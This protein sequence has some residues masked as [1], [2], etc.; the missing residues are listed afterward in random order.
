MYQNHPYPVWLRE[1]DG[2]M[3]PCAKGDPGAIE[4]YPVADPTSDNTT[5][6]Q[7]VLLM[8]MRQHGV[9]ESVIEQLLYGDHW[10]K[11]GAVRAIAKAALNFKPLPAVPMSRCTSCG[12]RYPSAAPG[13]L[14]KC[15]MCS[16]GMCVP[17]ETGTAENRKA[18]ILALRQAR[19]VLRDFD[20]KQPGCGFWKLAASCEE[21]A[22]YLYGRED[23]SAFDLDRQKLADALYASLAGSYDCSRVWEAWSVGTMTAND[24]TP[25]ED[26]ALEIAD[27]IIDALRAA[28][29]STGS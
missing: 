17:E 22:D 3:H 20:K 8:A 26:R 18:L 21:A 23:N 14:H 4:F 11:S 28:Q 6:M 19:Y 9:S 15:G 16:G 12:E 27:D 1:I 10:G 5:Q 2:S 24:F 7:A 25:M 29:E 13:H